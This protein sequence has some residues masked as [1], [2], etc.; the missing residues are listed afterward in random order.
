LTLAVT[1]LT[2][3]Q[4]R[5]TI[6][7]QLVDNV[8]MTTVRIRGET[9]RRFIIEHLDEHSSDI[10]RFAGE[11]FGYSRQAVHKHL[12]RLIAEGTITE[13]GQTRSKVYRLAPLVKW[14]KWYTLDGRIAEDVVWRNDVAPSLGN[15]PENVLNIWH[16]GFTEMF[17]NVIDHSGARYVFIS[18]TKT[19]AATTVSIHDDG[20]GIFKK[21]QA[22]LE[23]IDERHA[24]L[25]LA[26]GKFTT[27][28]A[29]HSGEGIFFSSRMFD[30]FNI[31]SGEVYFSHEFD[32]KEDWILQNVPGGGTLVTMVLHNHTARTA[33]KVFDKFT[34]DDDYGF[35]K[36]VVPVKLMQYGDDNLISRS[37]AK[38]LLA[39][40]DRFKIVILDF[41]GVASVGQ[42]F[43]DEVFRV[44]RLKHPEVELITIHTS[45]AV[46]RM[47]S[48]AEAL[49]AG[50]DG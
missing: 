27:D 46:K 36:T 2:K 50:G 12:Q 34:S 38:R 40:F 4:V 29:N 37:Q 15:L 17:N 7:N 25:E 13:S 3:K 20:V 9:V 8:H 19:A 22:A 6:V 23:L 14:E 48:R 49:S 45:S 41:S 24:V 39:R 1:G 47:I 26:K 42:A 16:Y 10:V 44:F 32:K 33:K 30:N 21:I 5:L 18:L 31:F 11:K 43:A 35:N 28:P